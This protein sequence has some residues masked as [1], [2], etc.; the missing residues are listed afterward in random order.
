M[1]KTEKIYPHQL[2]AA[3]V[4]ARLSQKELC[5]LAGVS[6][7]TLRRLE[8]ESGYAEIVTAETSWLVRRALEQQGVM[9]I[10]EENST[11][12]IPGIGVAIKSWP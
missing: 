10:T 1:K 9:F 4:L 12:S 2:K 7:V 5:A 8:S 6:L 3:R 11:P